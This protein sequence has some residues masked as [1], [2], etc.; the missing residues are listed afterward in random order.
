MLM[1]C[2]YIFFLFERLSVRKAFVIL[3]MSSL[4]LFFICFFSYFVFGVSGT[5]ITCLCISMKEKLKDCTTNNGGVMGPGSRIE[6]Q[7]RNNSNLQRIT[8]QM[9]FEA[10]Y[11]WFPFL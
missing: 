5:R 11:F 1:I 4:C 9:N 8:I 3:D 2:F 6:I 7:D 10:Y